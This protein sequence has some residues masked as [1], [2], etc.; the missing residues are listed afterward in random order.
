MTDG[1]GNQT[2]YIRTKGGDIAAV[3]DP[4]GN[5]TRYRYDKAHRL[6]NIVQG[7]GT[8]AEDINLELLED[9]EEVQK[10][11]KK[12]SSI[13]ITS[14]ARDILGRVTSVTDALGNVESY[15]YDRKG[16]IKAKTDMDGN[17]TKITRTHLGDISRI[18]YGDGED[19]EYSY[20]ALGQLKAIKDSLGL[21]KID[22]DIL[23]RER[24]ITDHKGRSIS[25]E[26]DDAGNRTGIRYANGKN[27]RYIYDERGLIAG[28]EVTG[29]DGAAPKM[30]S[31]SAPASLSSSPVPASVKATP[32]VSLSYDSY[33]RIVSKTVG[34]AETA[35]TYDK[36]GHLASLVN[37]KSGIVL[38]SYEYSYDQAGNLVAS[39]QKREG[40]PEA[41]GSYEYGYDEIGRLN[42]VVKDGNPLR[43]YTYDAFG[44]RT[45]LDEAGAKTEYL[46]NKANQLM[47]TD[48]PHGTTIF[49]HD[50]RG[51]VIHKRTGSAQHRV[52]VDYTYGANNRLI[53]AVKNA[54]GESLTARYAY[55]GLGMRVSRAT[56]TGSV[57]YILDQT[58]MYNNLLESI[59]VDGQDSMSN[60]IES[61]GN[62]R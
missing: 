11:N 15:E 40:M 59:Q 62:G 44:N 35:Y 60:P 8:E 55:N 43:S 2:K 30:K 39:C 6:M 45:I 32:A 36:C 22:R 58:Q 26:Y 25:Y 3:V 7:V 19:I 9:A 10:L 46:Y 53:Q 18:T 12:H 51:N 49:Q 27:V 50:K 48:T 21:T 38:D 20:N 28:I 42:R 52:S 54:D 37:K 4:L 47:R 24:S 13:R 1:L 33:G 34:P 17:R 5:V 56:D 57:D 23:G 16:H 29:I 14:Y 41:T 31:S 61:E